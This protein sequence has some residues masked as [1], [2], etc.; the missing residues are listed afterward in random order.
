MSSPLHMVNKK[1]GESRPCGDYKTS[2]AI[3]VPDRYPIPNI[4]DV[5]AK[6]SNKKYFSKIDLAEQLY[7]R[8]LRSASFYRSL[9]AKL[10]NYEINC[11]K[12]EMN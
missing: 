2:N 12:K 6:L 4:N 3:M 10:L 8:S 11:K 1:N 9:Q 5:S 7:K